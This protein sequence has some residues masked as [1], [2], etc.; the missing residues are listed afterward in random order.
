[1]ND[2]EKQKFLTKEQDVPPELI[3][4]L[5]SDGGVEGVKLLLEGQG[6]DKQAPT[7]TMIHSLGAGGN[8]V[9]SRWLLLV[10]CCFK[11]TKNL[12][13]FINLKCRGRWHLWQSKQPVF[14]R[15]ALMI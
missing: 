14:G 11:N 13:L 8:I 12:F 3:K 15:S 4:E 2:E 7:A 6:W 9:G 1:M 10:S 5:S